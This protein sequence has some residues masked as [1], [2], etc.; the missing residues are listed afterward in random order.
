MEKKYA[1]KYLDVLYYDGKVLPVTLEIKNKRRYLKFV[2]SGTTLKLEDCNPN[3]QTYN[4]GA[5]SIVSLIS[6]E[7]TKRYGE[8]GTLTGAISAYGNYK[9]L[10]KYPTISKMYRLLNHNEFEG[11]IKDSQAIGQYF[12]TELTETQIKDIFTCIQRGYEQKR[13][14]DRLA[15]DERN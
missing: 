4:Y 2:L 6:G 10:A 14:T 15:I 11:V 13:N 12:D 7:K 3:L 8:L 9:M 5:R 1:I